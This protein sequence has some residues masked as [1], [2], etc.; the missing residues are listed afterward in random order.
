MTIP[1]MLVGLLPACRA[2]NVLLSMMG[3]RFSIDRT[4]T[5][6]PVL[7]WRIRR[8]HVGA[9]CHIGPGNAFRDMRLV[10]LGDHAEIGQFNWFSA[11]AQHVPGSDEAVRASLVMGRHSAITS[12]HYVDC[13][14]G[15]RL[16]EAAVVAGVRST[17]LTHSMDARRWV[18]E[19]KPVVLGT[20]SALFTNVT[21]TAGAV[22]PADAVVAAGAVVVGTLTEPG[23]L[24][25]GTPAKAI[26]D[27][28]TGAHAG[29]TESRDAAPEVVTSPSRTPRARR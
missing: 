3:R 7:I 13:S 18:Q 22:V 25:G 8:L 11:A 4:A 10:E 1:V 27:V 2:K 23:Y 16:E 5:I 14:G 28:S 21:V 29:R 12:R 24:Y 26:A 9:S 15:L 20:S 19:T 6:H 17:I